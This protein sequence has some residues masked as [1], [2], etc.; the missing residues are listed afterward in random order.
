MI[1]GFVYSYEHK[2]SVEIWP[3]AQVL[4]LCVAMNTNCLLRYDLVHKH[5]IRGGKIAVEM[6]LV[7][8]FRRSVFSFGLS[9]NPLPAKVEN[10]VR[11]E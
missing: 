3:R 6:Q 8:K 10:M 5:Y 4:H 7:R 11:S 2:L 9:L 1:V